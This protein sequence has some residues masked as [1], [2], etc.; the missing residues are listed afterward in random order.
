M[1]VEPTIA[2]GVLAACN[3]HEDRELVTHSI[4]ISVISVEK[5]S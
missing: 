2:A 1:V 3:I 5:G 4:L